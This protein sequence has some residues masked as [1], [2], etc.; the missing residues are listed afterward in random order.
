MTKMTVVSVLSV[1]MLTA[2]TSA[3][4]ETFRMVGR[5]TTEAEACRIARHKTDDVS[6]NTRRVI[7]ISDCRCRA[8]ANPSGRIYQY[9]CEV[10]ATTERRH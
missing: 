5:A 2:A 3:H 6:S 7:S 8:R 10:T 9:D 4:A 1:A